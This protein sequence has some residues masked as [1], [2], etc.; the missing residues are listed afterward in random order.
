MRRDGNDRREL[1]RVFLVC[2]IRDI[3]RLTT[4]GHPLT[5]RRY[6]WLL[7]HLKAC[8]AQILKT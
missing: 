4:A 2:V 6:A 5:A 7:E 3:S 1:E 8:L